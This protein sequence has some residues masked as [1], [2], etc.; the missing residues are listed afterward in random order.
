MIRCDLEICV[1]CKSC[2]VTC[3]T[4]HYNAVSPVMS[5]IRVAKLEDTGIDMA[6]SCLSCIEKSCM[7][8]PNEALSVGK[9]GEI[10][11]DSE[12]C[13]AC[14]LCTETCPIGA[15]GFFENAPIFCDLCSG[16]K[17]CVQT[18]P[19]GALIY[20]ENE[21]VSLEKYLTNDGRAGSRRAAY[22]EDLAK[23]IRDEWKNGRRVDS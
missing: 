16:E 15:V 19:S 10:L 3:S 4:F 6:V 13:D 18:C 23:K 21:E 17:S 1:G 14:E 12:I 7:D 22:A 20:V 2:E 5:R 9:A 11:R 8:C